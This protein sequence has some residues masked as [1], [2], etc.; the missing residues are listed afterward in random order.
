[1]G[2]AYYGQ[3]RVK[4][5]D[6][7]KDLAD[8]GFIW[9]D[10]MSIPQ[11]DPEAQSRAISGSSSWTTTQHDTISKRIKTAQRQDRNTHQTKA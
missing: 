6:L 8:D 2:G 1:M 11:A 9:F 3:L 10:V 7:R 4:A 5:K